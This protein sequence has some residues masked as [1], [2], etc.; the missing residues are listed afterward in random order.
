MS[1]ASAASVTGPLHSQFTFKW[2]HLLF[3]LHKYIVVTTNS[4]FRN[5]PIK[6]R[7]VQVLYT[8]KLSG[9]RIV[10]ALNL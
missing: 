7:Q 9:R 2:L 1:T 10:E 6:N 8:E 5:N 3:F 4:Y